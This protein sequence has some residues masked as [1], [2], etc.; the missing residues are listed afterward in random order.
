MSSNNNI[1]RM[2]TTRKRLKTTAVNYV[3]YD[4]IFVYSNGSL[5]IKLP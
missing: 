4:F 3:S 1:A 2:P 5:M